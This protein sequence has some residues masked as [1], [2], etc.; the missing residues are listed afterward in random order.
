MSKQRKGPSGVVGK[1]KVRGKP[2]KKPVYHVFLGKENGGFYG[3]KPY[4]S[5]PKEQAK[6]LTHKEAILIEGRL[7]R[8]GYKGAVAVLA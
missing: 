6:P 5:V 8:I 4:E 1:S 7:R 3:E 2:G